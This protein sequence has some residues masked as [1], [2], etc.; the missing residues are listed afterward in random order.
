MALIVVARARKAEYLQTQP[1][2]MIN[3]TLSLP[4][5]MPGYHLALSNVAANYSD[6]SRGFY[7]TR[8]VVFVERVFPSFLTKIA[9]G[10]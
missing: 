3:F 1:L 4:L 5:D 2:W 8:M 10:G 9:S 7:Y 6:V